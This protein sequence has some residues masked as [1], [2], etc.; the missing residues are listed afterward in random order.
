MDLM[1]PNKAVKTAPFGRW[2]PQ[3][4]AALY[5]DRYASQKLQ[6]PT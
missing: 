2:T 1:T 6:F 3:K 4:R 5:L